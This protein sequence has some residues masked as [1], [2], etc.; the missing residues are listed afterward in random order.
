M[1][2]R[3]GGGRFVG[4]RKGGRGGTEGEIEAV[5]EGENFSRYFLNELEGGASFP[6][7]SC[8]FGC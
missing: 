2:G 6:T 1:R 4:V 7:V 8:L 5:G 3:W